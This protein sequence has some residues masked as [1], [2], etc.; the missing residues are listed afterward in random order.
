MSS[1]RKSII[2]VLLVIVFIIL[3]SFLF[4]WPYLLD[5]YREYTHRDLTY[6]DGYSDGYF[7]GYD[8]GREA[9]EDYRAEYEYE[10]I[11]S[12]S[13]YYDDA[14]SEGYHE[15]YAEGFEA[16]CNYIIT[17]MD[18]DYYEIWAAENED[19]ISEHD[20]SVAP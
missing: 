1:K 10:E 14:K 5:L 9:G 12:D 16:A 2:K 18:P 17:G 7:A 8:D 19:W 3:V 4:S 15:G 13:S 20:V 11:Y 6:E